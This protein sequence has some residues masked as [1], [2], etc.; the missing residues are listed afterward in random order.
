MLEVDIIRLLWIVNTRRGAYTQS[1][2]IVNINR[3]L[4]LE[5]DNNVG[6]TIFIKRTKKNEEQMI[7]FL[8]RSISS[9]QILHLLRKPDMKNYKRF[10]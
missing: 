3:E 1:G 10:N 4:I 5:V 7:F 2:L 6:I 8:S 9:M